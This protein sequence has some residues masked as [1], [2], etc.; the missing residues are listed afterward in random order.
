MHRLLRSPRVKRRADR[1]HKAL[2]GFALA[3]ALTFGGWA[4]SSCSS[5]QVN[6]VPIGEGRIGAVEWF[7]SVVRG[8]DAQGPVPCAVLVTR[9]TKPGGEP[10]TEFGESGVHV[11]GPLWTNGAPRVVGDRI[12]GEKGTAVAVLAAPAARELRLYLDGS[13]LRTFSLGL[14]GRKRASSIGLEPLRAV[15]F[16][17][18]GSF[19]IRRIVV[20]GAGSH[21]LYR[22]PRASC[23]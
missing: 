14:I 9:N 13:G 16:S 8:R 11:C 19:C 23:R 1:A 17:I 4:T 2:A 22:S 5:A 12:P 21:P 18:S 3:L 20:I 7:A 10:E 15:A 6:L